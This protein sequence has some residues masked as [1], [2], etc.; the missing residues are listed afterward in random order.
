MIGVRKGHLLFVLVMAAMPGCGMVGQAAAASSGNAHLVDDEP[1]AESA[2]SGS[3]TAAES[4]STDV[5]AL[6]LQ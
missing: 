4:T 3:Q 2:S 1:A 6:E 5:A